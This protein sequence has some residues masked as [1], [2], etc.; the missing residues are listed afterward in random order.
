MMK[1]ATFSAK[2]LFV[3]L[4]VSG[5]SLTIAG[6]GVEVGGELL[7]SMKPGN[8]RGQ[9]SSKPER[10]LQPD[11]PC[12]FG[13]VGNGICEDG[14]CCSPYGWCGVTAAHCAGS[15]GGTCG[16]GN[17]GNGICA[18]SSLCC[19]PY[20][21]CG[22]SEAHCAGTVPAPVAAPTPAPVAPTPAP[23]APTPAPVAAPTSTAT[24]GG[25]SRGNGI[26]PN[27]LCCSDWGWCGTSEAHC[28]SNNDAPVS[29]PEEPANPVVTDSPT[30]A[31]ILDDN[32]VGTCGGGSRGNGVC[33]DGLCCSPYGWCGTSSAH[34]ADSQPPPPSNNGD[35]SSPDN[36]INDPP[37][38]LTIK[39]LQAALDAYNSFWGESIQ[40]NQDLLDLINTVTTVPNRGWSLYR[41][42]AFVAQTIW[43]SGAFQYTEEIAA[44]TP[45][46][47][48]QW[49]Y[50]DCDWN[51]PG[52]QTP[53]NGK[54]FF[55]RGYIQLSWCANYKAYGANRMIN[56]DADFFYKNPE[57]VATPT[58]AMDSAAW[59][60]ENRV[61][62][63]SGKF[64]DTTND[65]NGVQECTGNG[66][67]KP[68]KR[69]EIFVAMA[70][71]VGLRG[72]SESG[73]YN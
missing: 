72:Y 9:S 56:G 61:Y 71:E 57:L 51:T 1:F 11:V 73:C 36:N 48:T 29:V 21:W 52:W 6:E 12:G 34:C 33:A 70:E 27:G 28:A 23:V 3:V 35:V 54:P 31:P 16:G 25:G 15:S 67:G 22:S 17:V 53:P 45:P 63:T 69:Y 13:T 8:L 60:F 46:Y 66:G 55:G 49:S 39:D 42:V 68:Q 24:C 5:D 40:A 50:Q 65:I 4:L 7:D 41:Q 20:G 47:S 59:F 30:N 32:V 44:T 38:A 43:E 18:D 14:N 2:A 10:I 37:K 58:Y 19:S 26:C 64:G 62:D